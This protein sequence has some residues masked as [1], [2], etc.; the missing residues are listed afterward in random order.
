MDYMI[1]RLDVMEQRLAQID[2]KLSSSSTSFA[3]AREL[4]KERATMEEACSLYKEYKNVL[5]QL[6]EAILMK[7]DED[8][9]LAMLGKEEANRLEA[10]KEE[11][12]KKMEVALL[13]KDANDDKNVVM[14]IRGAVGGEEA[15]LFAGDLYRMYLK[16]ADSQRW[17]V[18]LIDESPTS[19]GGYSQ[20]SFMIKGKGVYSKLKFESGSHRVQRVPR[21]ETSGRIHTST[22]TVLVMPEVETVDVEIN[23]ADLEI[24]TYRSQ[25]AGGQNVNKTESAV[26]ITHK[27]SGIVVTCQVERS[28]IQNREIA[29]QLLRSRLKAK[30]DEEQNEK[31]GKERRLKVGTGERSE[32]IRT[33][34]FPQNR[35]T[36]HRIGYTVNSLDR[37]LEGDLN[38]LISALIEENQKDLILEASKNN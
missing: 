26:R 33:Y 16:Y 29:M 14:E 22:A 5:S 34:N 31:I 6:E 17:K 4:N 19:L 23:P 18:Q 7:E 38:D 27:P 12:Y 32:K 11:L 37:I 20:V 15:D 36:D 10:L 3:E 24:D 8:E 13:P 1:N 30:I 2:E 35:V 21:T 9:E 25:G 28:Q